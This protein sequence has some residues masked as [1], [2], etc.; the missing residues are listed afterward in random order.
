MQIRGRQNCTSSVCWLTKFRHNNTNRSCGTATTATTTTTTT[1]TTAY[2]EL[3]RHLLFAPVFVSLLTFCCLCNRPIAK[4]FCHSH[5][6]HQK[7]ARLQ[8]VSIVLFPFFPK[9]RCFFI[10]LKWWI[11]GMTGLHKSCSKHF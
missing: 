1:I 10:A 2:P 11:G 6:G 3:L 4:E 9:Q 8:M 5:P 7:I